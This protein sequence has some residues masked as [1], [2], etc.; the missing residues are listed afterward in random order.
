MARDVDDALHEIV[1]GQGG[2]TPEAAADYV[3]AM[4]KEKRYQR[5]VY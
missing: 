5:D 4:K 2:L 1:E 3:K